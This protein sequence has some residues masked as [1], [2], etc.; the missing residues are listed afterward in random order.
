MTTRKRASRARP[1][2]HVDPRKPKPG[3]PPISRTHPAEGGYWPTCRD[4]G[5]ELH[6]PVDRDVASRMA[7]RHA[8]LWPGHVAVVELVTEAERSA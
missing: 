8:E 4:C 3:P 1:Y 7:G 6:W 5:G 2:V